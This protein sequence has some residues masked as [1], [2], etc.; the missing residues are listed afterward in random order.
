MILRQ[1]MIKGVSIHELSMPKIV[2]RVG[3]IFGALVHCAFWTECAMHQNGHN[4]EICLS[5]S[6]G[7]LCHVSKFTRI[8]RGVRFRA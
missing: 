5:I 4:D 7:K 1:F 8:L 3:N 2:T 6:D